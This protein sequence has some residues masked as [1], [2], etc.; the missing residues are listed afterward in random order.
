MLMKLSS[1]EEDFQEYVIVHELLHLRIPNHG[2]LF[3]NLISVYIPN[4][5]EIANRSE[6][7]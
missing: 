1:E 5:E 4:W 6:R 7:D 3:K 2:I